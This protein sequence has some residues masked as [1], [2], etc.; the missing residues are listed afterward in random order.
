MRIFGRRQQEV[1]ARLVAR[2]GDGCYLCGAKLD[3][4]QYHIEHIIPPARGGTNDDANLAIACVP[5]NYRKGDKIVSI[6]IA[7][8]MP[9]FSQ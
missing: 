1:I 3:R 5:C 4:G 8:R 6:T 7:E 9:C 2:D